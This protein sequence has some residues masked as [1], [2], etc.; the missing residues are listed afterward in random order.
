MLHAGPA[1]RP[2]M[3][4]SVWRRLPA[5]SPKGCRLTRRPIGQLRIF[6]TFRPRIVQR[7]AYQCWRI[8]SVVPTRLR[9]RNMRDMQSSRAGE[10]VPESIA[11]ATADPL[12]PQPAAGTWAATVRRSELAAGR[13]S[14]P[15]PAPADGERAQGR[16]QHDSVSPRTHRSTGSRRA[17]F[18]YHPHPLQSC[19]C[20]EAFYSL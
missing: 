20:E 13:Q 6:L 17:R 7:A 16:A 10:S 3:G 8:S 4:S 14:P 2:L 1:F 9:L 11:C 5:V 19:P 15:E 18:V 12:R